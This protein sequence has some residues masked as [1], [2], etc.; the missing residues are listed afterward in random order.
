MRKG[1]KAMRHMSELRA[2]LLAAVTACA[3]GLPLQASAQEP[4]RFQQAQSTFHDPL[5]CMCRA[6][7]RLFQLGEK[8]CLR[9]AEGPRMAECQMVT[10]VTSWGLT[11][12]PCPE[13]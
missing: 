7:G 9:T 8:I 3:L 11:E 10:N 5:N 4:G 12:R 6:Q 2:V 1:A 13:S